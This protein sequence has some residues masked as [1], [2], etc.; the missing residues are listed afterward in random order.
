MQSARGAA[1]CLRLVAGNLS[2]WDR[3]PL[4][5]ACHSFITVRFTYLR[6]SPPLQALKP[7]VFVLPRPCGVPAPP[8]P[9]L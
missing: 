4:S 9:I 2:G 5:P 6:P 7:Q 1:T 3:A 8:P